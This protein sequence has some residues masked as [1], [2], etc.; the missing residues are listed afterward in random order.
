MEVGRLMKKKS[1]AALCSHA[2]FITLSMY[3]S[4]GSFDFNLILVCYYVC[5]YLPKCGLEI[6]VGLHCLMWPSHVLPWHVM[7]DGWSSQTDTQD[8]FSPTRGVLHN[9]SSLMINLYVWPCTFMPQ[10]FVWTSI[11]EKGQRKYD[12]R[13][14]SGRYYT[15]IVSV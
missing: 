4:K 9:I 6:L 7:D 14:A 5:G 8:F 13:V 2:C 15:T 10:T 3:C 12:S 1:F 11:K